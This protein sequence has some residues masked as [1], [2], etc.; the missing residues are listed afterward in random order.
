M[1][2][3]KVLQAALISTALV[4]LGGAAMAAGTTPGTTINNSIDVSYTSGGNTIT[5]T[6]ESSVSFKVD[7]KVDFTLE[8]QDAGASVSVSQGAGDQQLTFRLV[9]EG[10]DSSSFDID[11]ASSGTLGL[12]YDAS[13]AGAAGTYSVYIGSDADPVD[14]DDVLYDAAGTARLADIVNADGIVYIKILANIPSSATDGQKDDFTVTATAL[15]AGT[16]TIT[17][18]TASPTIDNVDT[19]LADA[20]ADG[21]EADAEDFT[22]SAPIL[23]GS[24]TSTLVSENLDGAFNC[25]V[26]T[27]DGTASAFVPGACVEYTLGVANSAGATSAATTLTLTDALPADVTFVTVLSNTGFDSVSE[28][29]GTIT[30]TLS[31]LAAGASAETVIRVTID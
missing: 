4:S 6:N 23:T 1:T 21:I 28:S 17:T 8:G 3:K 20:D 22:V 13:G 15:N 16:D 10:N 9:N 7:R 24:K 19:F 11:V 26:G 14:G 29:N 25:A 31:S 12:T 27:V 2:M 5:R 30:A 18:E